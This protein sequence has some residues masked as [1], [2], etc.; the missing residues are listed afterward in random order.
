MKLLN[1]GVT[2]AIAEINKFNHQNHLSHHNLFL[3][4][5]GSYNLLSATVITTTTTIINQLVKAQFIKINTLHVATKKN[6]NLNQSFF[7]EKIQQIVVLIEAYMPQIIVAK[8]KRI[9]NLAK[10]IFYI[11]SLEELKLLSLLQDYSQHH[12]KIINNKLEMDII[13]L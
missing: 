8:S 11:Q 6:N 2:A 4:V 5:K 9:L 13:L 10:I 1:Q 7:G 3:T 12:R